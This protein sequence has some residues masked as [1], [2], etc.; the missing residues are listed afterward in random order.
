VTVGTSAA[1]RLVQPASPGAP[2]PPLSPR[3]WRYRVD[4]DRIVTGAAYSNGGNLYAWARRELRLPEGAALD[5]ALRRHD[6]GVRADPRL[7]GD[8]PPGRTPAGSGTLS[9]IGFTTT[10][11]DLLAALM[12][13]V[14]RQVVE[15]VGELETA[16]TSP[17]T[18]MLGGGAVAAS[19]WWR[20]AFRAA[21]A[22]RDVI[23]VREPEV[24]A[25]GAALIAAG[26]VD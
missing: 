22:P 2:L 17:V 4:H 10:A 23:D 11:A 25:V 3:L 19:S 14:C 12:D 8:R 9:G 20:D 1:V 15:D 16:L 7:G 6:P 21:L 24:G 18:V 5:E 13:G 26:Q